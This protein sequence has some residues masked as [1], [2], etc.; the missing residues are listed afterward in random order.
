M[1]RGACLSL[2]I[3]MIAGCHRYPDTPVKAYRHVGD[4]IKAAGKGLFGYPCTKPNKD[5]PR[6]LDSTPRRECYRFDPPTRMSGIWINDFEGSH[7][8]ADG[9]IAPDPNHTY[10]KATWLGDEPDGRVLPLSRDGSGYGKVYAIALIGSRTTYAGRY[11]HVGGS[12]YL[13]LADRLI[14]IREVPRPKPG[15]LIDSRLADRR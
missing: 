13:I 5:D 10:G 4:Q 12:A 9:S 2:A 7:F 11:G 3:L 14:S 15:E 1:K 6:V 8:L